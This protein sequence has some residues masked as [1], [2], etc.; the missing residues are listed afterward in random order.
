VDL[1]LRP[2]TTLSEER[3]VFNQNCF[4]INGVDLP[5]KYH[6][7]V[8]ALASDNAEPDAVDIYAL[9]VFEVLKGKEVRLVGALF[10][11]RAIDEYPPS[12]T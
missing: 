8:T 2:H 5:P 9:E 6:V 7:G 4:T 10:K 11:S 1:D 12:Y 3:R